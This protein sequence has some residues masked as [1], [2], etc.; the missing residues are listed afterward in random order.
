MHRMR[1]TKPRKYDSVRD[2]LLRAAR[3]FKKATG[4]R[5]TH[6]CVP[7]NDWRDRVR[8]AADELGLEIQVDLEAAPGF[9]YLRTDGTPDALEIGNAT[10]GA[11]L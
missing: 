1:V 6:V 7:S 2:T 8:R 4:V 11:D 10:E 9:L 3:D 5:A